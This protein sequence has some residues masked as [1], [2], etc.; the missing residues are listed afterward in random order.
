VPPRVENFLWRACR[1]VQPTKTRVRDKE[2]EC[3]YVCTVCKSTLMLRFLGTQEAWVLLY[4]SGMS[5]GIGEFIQA[6]P[7]N[8]TK[9]LMF[10]K[11][12]PW[13][14]GLLSSGYIN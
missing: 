6:I 3:P 1:D 4:A 11:V 10:I 7:I 8:Y 14:F 13:V 12:K 5:M 9:L 2:V